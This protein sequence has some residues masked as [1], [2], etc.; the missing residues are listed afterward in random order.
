[1]LISDLG[2]EGLIQEIKRLFSSESDDVRVD[3]G[4]DAAVVDVSGGS[5]VW[6]TDILIESI[7]FRKEW[8]A[9]EELGMKCV[10]AN[11]SDL[12]SMGARPL[13][14]LLSLGI[15]RDV[16]ADLVLSICSGIGRSAADAGIRMVGGDTSASPGVMVISIALM[17]AVDGSPMTRAGARPGD[18]IIVTGA[19]GAAAAGL[20]LL[21]AGTDTDFPGLVH[22]FRTPPDRIEA[23]RVVASAGGTAMTDIS[24][25][26]ATDLRHLCEA[27]S[28]GADIDLSRVPLMDGLEAACERLSLDKEEL[29]LCGGEDYE[30]LFTVAQDAEVPLLDAVRKAGAPKAAVIG[31]ITGAEVGIFVTGF[32]GGK[33]PLKACG[34]EH[35]R[36]G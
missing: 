17:G 27:S 25:G 10:R 5:Q 13:F 7:H 18:R 11:I 4:D 28:A 32:D 20:R 29:V 26:L 36:D 6:T 35:F 22:A 33:R 24:D 8:Q 9:P 19:L 31:T 2:E 14:G 12:A 34:Y 1:M 15:P 21:E 23:G 3:I 16:D 30:L